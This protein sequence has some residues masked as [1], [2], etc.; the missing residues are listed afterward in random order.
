M[1]ED[2]ATLS[3]KW[4]LYGDKSL[5]GVKTGGKL[6]MVIVLLSTLQL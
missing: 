4:P 3:L 5:N 6:L 2:K 1:Y